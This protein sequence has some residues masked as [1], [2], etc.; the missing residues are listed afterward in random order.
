MRLLAIDPGERHI[1]VAVSDPS[2]IIA[3]PL[4]TLTHE[5]RA[6]DAERLL[7]LA[8][9]HEVAGI[10]VGI[11]FDAQGEA[12]PQA[13]QAQR[14]AEVL[15]TLTPL[16]VIPHDESYS[17]AAARAMMLAS[18]KK[19]RER[20]EQIHAIAAAVLLQSYLDANPVPPAPPSG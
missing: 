4:T 10:V 16:P 13:R 2:G 1:G 15:R 12:G 14:L 18:G 9:E 3:R 5:S 17:S 20:R 11:A 19:R 8:L 6:K 7:A